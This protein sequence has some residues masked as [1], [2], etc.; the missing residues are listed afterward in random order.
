MTFWHAPSRF[1]DDHIWILV[2]SSVS[3]ANASYLFCGLEKALEGTGVGS[4]DG[5]I[6]MH[7]KKRGRVRNKNENKLVACSAG[8]SYIDI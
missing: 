7:L 5:Q 6:H 2:L 3:S 8:A 1:F 4:W